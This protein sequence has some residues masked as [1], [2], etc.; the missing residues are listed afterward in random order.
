MAISDRSALCLR[1]P[2]RTPS[3]NSKVL[4]QLLTIESQECVGSF[5]VGL[6]FNFLTHLRDLPIGKRFVCFCLPDL[7][8]LGVLIFL[9]LF[10][11]GNSVGVSSVF[12]CFSLFFQGFYLG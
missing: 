1:E 3:K 4:E 8:F 7:P 6:M 9:G 10:N 5:M 2:E 12:S 11:Q